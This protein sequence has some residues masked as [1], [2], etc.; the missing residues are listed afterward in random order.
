MR[1][2]KGIQRSAVLFVAGTVLAGFAAQQ[3]C[4]RTTTNTSTV[5]P[6]PVVKTAAV[7]TKVDWMQFGGGPSHPGNNTQETQVSQSTVANLIKLFQVG[8]PETAEGQPVVL[9]GV[10]T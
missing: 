10:S 4:T 3:G 2:S 6:D 9:T 8:L 5:E 1:A 7:V